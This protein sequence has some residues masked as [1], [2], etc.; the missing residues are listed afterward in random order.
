MKITAISQRGKKRDFIDLYWLSLHVQP[1]LKS[2]E[3][4]MKQYSV[5]QNQNHILK[6]LVFFDDADS[7]PMPPL[8]FDATWEGI[9]KYFREETKNI[10]KRLLGLE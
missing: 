4:S 2:I 9:K 10:A 3:S 6:S 1:L 5:R 8:L 7:D